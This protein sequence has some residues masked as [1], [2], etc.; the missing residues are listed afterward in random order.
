MSQLTINECKTRR[1]DLNV[2]TSE[3][4]AHYFSEH[5][6]GQELIDAFSLSDY[7]LLISSAV[8]HE[9][10]G[11]KDPVLILEL[12]TSWRGV[13]IDDMTVE[14]HVGEKVDGLNEA[15]QASIDQWIERAQTEEVFSAQRIYNSIGA[16]DYLTQ[17]H[18]P[19]HMGDF[20]L[21]E[22]A[23]FHDPI[24][25][26]ITRY[27]HPEFADA[28]VD[29]SVYPVSP[30]VHDE[31]AKNTSAAHGFDNEDMNLLRS[32]MTL[33]RDEIK[34]LIDEAE[35]TDFVISDIET[36]RFAAKDKSIDGIAMEVALQT[37][38]DPIYST[39]IL[40]K[41]HDK[42]VKVTGNIPKQMMLALVE[43]SITEI[44]VPLESDFMQSMR[45]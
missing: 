37:Q 45:R 13:I 20:H 30:F 10:N 23:L 6:L 14:A 40:L 44:A 21:L 5:A 35:L 12:T 33:E 4:L 31:D 22:T 3:S 11:E 42:F 41:Q 18:L 9:P 1:C 2:F 25:G 28:V 19:E 32:E 29:I 26:S 34:R 8:K 17:M 16:S 38:I 39:Q 7:E 15:L 43:Q 36:T 27:V 24:Q